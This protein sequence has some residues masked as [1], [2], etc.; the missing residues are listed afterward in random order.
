MTDRLGEITAFV[1]VA[2]LRSFVRAAEH[3]DVNVS[4]VS[5][6]VASLESRLGVRLLQRSTRRVGLSEAG[7]LHLA[8]CDALLTELAEAEA[9]ISERNTALRGSLRI[10]VPSGFGLI[11]LAPMLPEFLRRHPQLKIDMQMSNR[12]VDLIEEDYDV[13]IR[14]GTLR[15]SRLAARKLAS[16]RRVLIAAPDYLRAHAPLRHPRDLS[17]HACLILEIGAHPD[18]WTLAT[19]TQRQGVRVGGPLRS[20]HVLAIRSACVGGLGVSLLPR[21]ALREQLGDGSLVQLLPKWQTPEQGIYAVYPSHRFLPAKVR[22]LVDFI[23]SQL[24]DA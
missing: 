21:F 5:R 6:A 23:E 22:A 7:R 19:Q 15:D 16:N 3:L 17:A 20:N 24:R 9:A 8:R 13:A 11:H 18:V 10:S 1:E 4:A 2:R 12:F 14:V